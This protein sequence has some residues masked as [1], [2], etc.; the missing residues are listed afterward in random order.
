MASQRPPLKSDFSTTQ[1]SPG[2]GYIDDAPLATSSASTPS[3]GY[4][5]FSK[6]VVKVLPKGV[7]KAVD[8]VVDKHHSTIRQAA[9]E[10]TGVMILI[11]FGAGVN[12]QV[13]L[14]SDAGVASSQKGDWLSVCFGWAIGIAMGAWISGDISG[15]H[16]NPAVTLAMAIWRGFPWKKVPIYIIAQILGGVVGAAIIY[17]NYFHAIDIVEGG[18]GIRTLKTAGLFATYPLDYMTDVSSFFSEF[19]GTA[20]LLIMLLALTDKR[21]SPPPN[22]LLPLALFILF[23]GIGA[24]LGMETGFALNAARDLGPRLLTSMVGYG[25][26]VYNF[27]N[28]YWLWGPVLAPILGAQVGAAFYVSI[29][30]SNTDDDDANNTAEV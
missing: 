1:V 16:I 12:C 27:R 25:A 20:V 22:G 11:I 28:Q 15:G 30:S 2:L 19:L 9:A 3:R 13:G 8:K 29:L 18:A 6:R 10:F 14:S 24:S 5:V 21:A 23:I 4:N 26:T 17:A 7:V